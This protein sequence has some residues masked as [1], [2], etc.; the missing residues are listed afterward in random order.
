M[1]QLVRLIEINRRF[2]T[3]NP[4]VPSNL[5]HQSS[6]VTALLAA[7]ALHIAVLIAVSEKDIFMVSTPKAK[8]NELQL[9][10]EKP[11]I[12]T[13]KQSLLVE[14]VSAP[15]QNRIAGEPAEPKQQLNKDAQLTPTSAAVKQL[16]DAMIAE[17]LKHP[18]KL[19]AFAQTFAEPS[20]HAVQQTL[21]EHSDGTVDV[22][23]SLFGRDICYSFDADGDPPIAFFNACERPE[24]IK[25]VLD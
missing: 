23:T 20:P 10:L 16:V 11:K 22:Q 2:K 1:I 3:I 25:L 8:S 17:E 7:I 5:P 19:T 12:N 9:V 15:N 21:Q 14:P 18:N 4:T 13:H 6:I 24:L